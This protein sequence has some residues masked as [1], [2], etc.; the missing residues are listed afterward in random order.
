MTRTKSS[1][2]IKI[3]LGIFA[4]IVLLFFIAELAVRA[5]ISQQIKDSFLDSAP[6]SVTVERA[7]DVHFGAASVLFGLAQG[8]LNHINIDLPSTLTPD[9]AYIAGTPAANIDATGFVLDQDDP[10]ADRVVVH[11]TLPQAVV[12]DMLQQELGRSLEES[13]NGRFAEYTGIITVSDVRTN[14]DSGTFTITFSNGAFA[15]ELRPK[16]HD[17]K[18][19]FDA[20]STQILGR[21]LPDF[22]SDAVGVALERGLN[23]QVVGPMRIDQFDVVDGGFDV[24]ITGEQVHLNDLQV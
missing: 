14:A 21:T 7:P 20:V 1:R 22:F 23:D 17:G 6:E 12:R 4:V 18:P 11:T 8:K 15:V 3:V 2:G 16:V 13:S 19:D 10:R 9:S 24:T 5:F